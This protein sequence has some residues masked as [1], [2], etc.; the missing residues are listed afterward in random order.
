M[1]EQKV[2]E[3]PLNVPVGFLWIIF[4]IVIFIFGVISWILVHHW[5]YYGVKGNRKVFAKSLYFIGS[6]IFIILSIIFIGAYEI[7]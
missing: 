1:F 2:L 7:L 6:I 5:G 4:L 3:I